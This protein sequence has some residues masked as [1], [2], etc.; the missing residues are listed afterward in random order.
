MSV[1]TP[2]VTRL[3]DQHDVNVTPGAGVDGQSLTYDYATGKFVTTN[4]ALAER[5]TELALPRSGLQM[6]LNA[7]AIVGVGNG[8]ALSSWISSTG[9]FL[10]ATGTARPTLVRDGTRY[11]VRFNGTS[12]Y[13]SA[14]SSMLTISQPNTTIVVAKTDNV[15]TTQAL[16]DGDDAGGRQE[17]AIV[18][19]NL[20]SYAGSNTT[21]FASPTGTM[22]ITQYWDGAT[23]SF[24]RVNGYVWAQTGVGTNALQGLVLGAYQPK[25]GLFFDGDVSDVLLYNR[26]LAL[27]ELE[28]IE[29]VLA[30]KNGLTYR[31]IV[32]DGDSRTAGNNV[33]VYYDYPSQMQ[34][35]LGIVVRMLN[36]GIGGYPVSSIILE[37]PVRI[38]PIRFGQSNDTVVIFGGINDIILSGRS[39]AQ[40]Y[41]DL[42][43]YWAARRAAGWKIVACT[44]I[45]ANSAQAI[46]A[47]WRTKR[48]ELN[49]LIKSDPSLYDALADLAV[50]ARIGVDGAADTA[51]FVSD[52]VHP[53][54]TG[55]TAM[56][57]LIGAAILTI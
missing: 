24:L 4:V 38:D 29:Y 52:K 32:C 39:A 54:A 23:G 44:E 57:E 42:V 14:P 43:T 45:D 37:A 35:Q 26:M 17:I 31:Q 1:A 55:N 5:A 22:I 6:R 11:V 21:S 34:R 2:T 33:A 46:S 9:K 12:N 51:Y 49:V 40:V 7:N 8:I 27:G 3:Q 56:A 36:T 28:A 47:D 48:A 20:F 53:S 18:S 19:G 50:D 30:T 41:A 16:V 13:M 15:A 10:L 25:D